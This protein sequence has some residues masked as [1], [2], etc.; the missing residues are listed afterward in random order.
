MATHPWGL[1]ALARGLAAPPI[2]FHQ[3]MHRTIALAALAAAASGSLSLVALAPAAHAADDDA[4]IE[5]RINAWGR[6]CKNAIA[7]KYNARSMA[8][9]DVTLG[10]TLKASIDAGETTLAD[11]KKGGLSFNFQVNHVPGTDPKG[12]CNTDGQ[13]NVKEITPF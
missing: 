5:A 10:E 13:G 6:N 4:K 7:E 1:R 2:P 8:D 9:V 3:P 12:Y 11:I